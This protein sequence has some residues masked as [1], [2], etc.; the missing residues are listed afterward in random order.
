M[1]QKTSLGREDIRE[2]FPDKGRPEW[3]AEGHEGISQERRKR[4]R[5]GGK[6]VWGKDGE[7]YQP[8]VKGT[9]SSKGIEVREKYMVDSEEFQAVKWLDMIEQRLRL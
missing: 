7:R 5:Q 8:Q 9:G 6:G 1:G 4:K 3:N 2:F